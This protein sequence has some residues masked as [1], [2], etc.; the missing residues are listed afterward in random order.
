[1]DVDPPVFTRVNRAYTDEDKHRYMEQG[2]C[3]KCGKKGHQAC[4]CPD[5]KEQPFKSTQHPKKGAFTPCPSKQSF[6]QHSYPPK[7]TQGFRKS[8]KPKGYFNNMNARVA[9][10]EEV[11]SDEED[12]E[13]KESPFL[14]ARTAQLSEEQRETLLEEIQDINANF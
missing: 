3:F 12:N 14:A 7:R 9:S 5:Q 2:L 4:Q 11:S 6:K 10:I 8:N 1:M 13:D